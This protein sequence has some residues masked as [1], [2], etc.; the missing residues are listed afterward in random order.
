MSIY[1]Q[2]VLELRRLMKENN[3]DAYLI[4]SADPHLSEYLPEYYK[5][6]VFIS[7]FKGSVGTV[8]ITQEEG[9]LWVD[10]RYWLQAQKELEGSGILLQKQDAKNTFTQWLEKNLSEDQILGIDFAL[11][12]LS[13]QKDLQINCKANLKHIDL[14]SPLW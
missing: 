7:G 12:P 9:F 11:L 4:L 13:L 6:R 2:R 1:K 14:I 3:I 10:G 8:L 5:N